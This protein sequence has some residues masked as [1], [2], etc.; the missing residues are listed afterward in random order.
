VHFFLKSVPT[1]I[2]F[3]GKKTQNKQFTKAIQ[4][5][6]FPYF[7]NCVL[8]WSAAPIANAIPIFLMAQKITVSTITLLAQVPTSTAM[9]STSGDM[10]RA[11]RLLSEVP[12]R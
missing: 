10:H 7:A 1:E 12:G 6:R 5:H 11:A 9:P 8:A 2:I 4:N 3:Q